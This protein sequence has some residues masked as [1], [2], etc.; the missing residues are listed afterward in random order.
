MY[1]NVVCEYDQRFGFTS[2]FPVLWASQC[3]YSLTNKT[4]LFI[5]CKKD[6]KFENPNS[7]SMQKILT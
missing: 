3:F 5:K 4:V 2:Y 1:L 7:F 6:E